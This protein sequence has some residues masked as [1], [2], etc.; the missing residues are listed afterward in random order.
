MT[1]KYHTLDVFTDVAF[2]GNPLACKLNRPHGVTVA[3]DG[4]LYITDSY[5]DRILRIV[6]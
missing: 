1:Y 2:G 4:V 6:P 3:P 5:N